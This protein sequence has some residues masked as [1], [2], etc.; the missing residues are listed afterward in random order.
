[1]HLLPECGVATTLPGALSPEQFSSNSVWA[2]SHISLSSDAARSRVIACLN[3]LCGTAELL[4]IEGNACYGATDAEREVLADTS[5]IAFIKEHCLSSLSSDV[6]V[7]LLDAHDG[8]Y[9]IH[10]VARAKVLDERSSWIILHA[11]AQSLQQGTQQN[12]VCTEES[13]TNVQTRH[14]HCL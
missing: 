3:A 8:V 7:Q 13:F 1:M 5:R 11:L 12:S 14:H 10:V 9:L 6:H 4:L 2:V